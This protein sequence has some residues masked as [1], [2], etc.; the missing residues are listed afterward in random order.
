MSVCLSV[1]MV[2]R[3]WAR[4]Y[5][6]VRGHLGVGHCFYHVFSGD[7]TWAIR[8]GNK[9]WAVSPAPLPIGFNVNMLPS[10]LAC[11]V[12][13]IHIV[14]LVVT[15]LWDLSG[16]LEIPLFVSQYASPSEDFLPTL[17]IF[18]NP[19]SLFSEPLARKSYQCAYSHS[20][21]VDKYTSTSSGFLLLT[22]PLIYS[23]CHGTKNVGF[24]IS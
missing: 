10:L 1:Y 11:S 8:P 21:L 5:V 9:C 17:T 19:I 18:P 4:S 7:P 14:S 3:V 15:F 20:G 23:S 2:R 6:V 16:N 13:W 24:R 22:I 12:S